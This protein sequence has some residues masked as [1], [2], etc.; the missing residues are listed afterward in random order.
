MTAHVDDRFPEY[1]T[2]SLP[3]A[4]ARAVEEHCAACSRCAADLAATTE[5]YAAL[6]LAIPKEAAPAADL[7]RL[8]ERVLAS[9]RGGGRLA[10][11]AE[12]VAALLDVAVDAARSLLDKIDD[13]SSWGEGPL[14]TGLIHL[15]PGPAAA[16]ANAGFIRIAAGVDFP[17]HRHLGEERIMV[18]QGSYQ[19]SDGTILRRGDVSIKPAGSEHSFRVLPGVDLVYLVVL[20]EGVVIPGVPGFEF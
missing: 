5:A 2:G 16:A 15:T 9:A 4:E 12:R 13:P 1:L 6:A 3:A 8:R 18:L 14:G 17:H 11:F 20:F 10:Q 19:D 7:V